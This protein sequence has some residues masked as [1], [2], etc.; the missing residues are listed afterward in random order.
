MKRRSDRVLSLPSSPS[1]V[2]AL[3]VVA[4]AEEKKAD[5]KK[6]AEDAEALKR[7]RKMANPPSHCAIADVPAG[8]DPANYYI[9]SGVCTVRCPA[10]T[11][12][13]V[14][15]FS[16]PSSMSCWSGRKGAAAATRA[17]A[18]STF[19]NRHR[20]LESSCC[21]FQIS[22][23]KFTHLNTTNRCPAPTILHIAAPS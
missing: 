20:W 15:F 6:A 9:C 4:T 12:S 3:V 19:P 18:A 16:N 2:L 5:P 11:P 17:V 10:S 7:N 21:A 23:S 8:E 13:M 14:C 1:Q 22:R